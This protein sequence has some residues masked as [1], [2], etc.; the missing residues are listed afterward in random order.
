[1]KDSSKENVKERILD[2]CE[3]LFLTKGVST[4]GVADIAKEVGISKG[5]LYYH[6]ANKEAI[7]DAVADRYFTKTQE[8]LEQMMRIMVMQQSDIDTIVTTMLNVIKMKKTSEK[9]HYTL[10]AY[11][12]TVYEPLLEKFR[13]RYANWLSMIKKMLDSYNNGDADNDLY[14]HLLLALFD[15]LAIKNIIGING[16]LNDIEGFVRFF[17]SIDFNNKKTI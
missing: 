2:I 13:D 6:Y 3:R 1:M 16:L 14:S 9:M 8:A 5:T 12:T 10:M 15:G 7:I 4:T 11:G 17:K